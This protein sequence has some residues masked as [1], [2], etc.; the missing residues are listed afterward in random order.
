MTTRSERRAA[1]AE[2]GPPALTPSD[3]TTAVREARAQIGPEL[4]STTTLHPPGTFTLEGPELRSTPSNIYLASL[5]DIEL[6]A[7]RAE[8]V[9]KEMQGRNGSRPLAA[10]ISLLVFAEEIY[11]LAVERKK[12]AP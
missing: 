6:C 12:G 3:H 8:T 9:L 7:R 11:K 5:E 10:H 1:R 4:E 2:A